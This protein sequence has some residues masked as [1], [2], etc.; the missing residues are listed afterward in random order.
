LIE[1]DK[2]YNPGVLLGLW[3]QNIIY[4]GLWLYIAIKM[5]RELNLDHEEG[6]LH[7]L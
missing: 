3:L 5:I 7:W 1:W 2:I 6:V 4:L